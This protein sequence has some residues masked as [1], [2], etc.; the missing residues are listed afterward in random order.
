M[1]HRSPSWLRRRYSLPIP[2]PTMPLIAAV[3][4]QHGLQL[5]NLVP[6]SHQWR[7]YF[8]IISD[9]NNFYYC[10]HCNMYSNVSV[11]SPR[12]PTDI[13][14]Q[15]VKPKFQSQEMSVSVSSFDTSRSSLFTALW[16]SQGQL[17]ELGGTEQHSV[18]H[19]KL[20][21]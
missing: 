5:L 9:K 19:R 1:L 12:R 6:L 20:R 17:L 2:P 13:S 14:S 21:T 8:Q 15:L 4:M 10:N 16:N 7:R 11:T 18:A 3:S